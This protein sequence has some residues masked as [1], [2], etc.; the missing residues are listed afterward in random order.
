MAESTSTNPV[1][2][3]L[4]RPNT[5]PVKTVVVTLAV[6][7]ICAIAVSTAAVSLRPIQQANLDAAR[8]ARM[9]QMVANLPG[10]GDLIME[11]GADSLQAML[12]DI[13]TGAPVTDM[14]AASYDQ[15]AAAADPET[16]LKL[17]PANDTVKLGA[18]APYA[19]VY[20]LRDGS[21]DLAL[22]VLPVSGSGYLSK[23]YGY[24]ALNGDLE[25]IAAL[26]FYEQAE[27]PGLGARIQDPAWEALWPG[28]Q[29]ANDQ[30]EV[31][32]GVV[33]GK[34]TEAWEVDGI[35]GA[36]NTGTGVTNLLRF[37]LGP[38]GY[39]PFL[40]KLKNGEIE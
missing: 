17:D 20:L 19:P 26:T 33:K 30:G 14:D 31:A 36:T 38:N 4:D 5:D 21:G 23:L 25:T 27:T 2:N 40:E 10:L 8:Q 29:I 3:I 15:K 12:V 39:G 24:L 1:R 9:Q 35:S 11:A 34:A 28:T 37:W 6:A 32:V 22:V 7:L 16:A 18:I 13:Q